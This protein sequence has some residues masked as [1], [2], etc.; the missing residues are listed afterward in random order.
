VSD[1]HGNI[2][3]ADTHDDRVLEFA[4]GSG[5]TDGK[6]AALVL[7]QLDFTSHALI[8]PP[9]KNSLSFPWGMTFDSKG[10]LYVGEVFSCRVLV[11]KPNAGKFHTDQKAA[12]VL[13][14]SDFTTGS[15][16]VSQTT[17][18]NPRG[19]GFGP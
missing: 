2:W 19:L 4:L 18:Q 8:V 1:K 15:C 12:L 7:G 11:F 14:H 13:G 10:N 17:L 6:D 5:F 9:T 16:A 3:E